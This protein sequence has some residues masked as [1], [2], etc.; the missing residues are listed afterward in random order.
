MPDVIKILPP[1][2]TNQISA[3]EVIERPASIIKELVENSID[4]GSDEIIVNIKQ[5]GYDLIIVRDNGVGISKNDLPLAICR[6]ATSKIHAFSDLDELKS[7]GFRGEALASICAVAKVKITSKYKYS[8][9]HDRA[10]CLILDQASQDA[11][12]YSVIPA[13]HPVGT[14]IEIS[15]LFYNTPVRKRFQKSEKT[16]FQHVLEIF[17]KLALSNLHCSFSFFNDDKLIY[18]LLKNNKIHRVQKIFGRNF[19]KN[20]IFFIG[21]AQN[22]KLEGW[23]GNQYYHRSQSDQQYFFLNNRVIRDKLILNAIK[24]VYD[25]MI[26]VGRHPCYILYL[27]LDPDQIDVNVHPAKHEV[28]FRDSRW[29]HQFMTQQLMRVLKPADNSNQ[30]SY[31][32]ESLLKQSN[33]HVCADYPIDYESNQA[34]QFGNI[35]ADLNNNIVVTYNLSHKKYYI[36]NLATSYI[37]LCYNKLLSEWSKQNYLTP[38]VVALQQELSVNSNILAKSKIL[39]KLGIKFTEHKNKSENKLLISTLPYAL[40]FAD[41]NEVIKKY[42]ELNPDESQLQINNLFY[43]WA[44]LALGRLTDSL[45]LSE[46]KAILDQID[47]DASDA[48][49]FG[50]KQL[51]KLLEPAYLESLLE[52]YEPVD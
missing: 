43:H 5:A 12:N 29:V 47:V 38:S 9:D 35:I 14:T 16:E 15:D 52:V 39:N 19:V 8:E 1:L 11:D 17:Q 48:M 33:A 10:Y 51:Y 37:Y 44:N 28:R 24:Q 49:R 36:I 46:Q 21:E 22:I 26:P 50:S 34:L 32:E 4:A 23:L 40:R 2:I 27:Y 31:Q 20:S 3:G 30:Q 41:P 7:L 18:R 45:L 13:A 25:A 42:F 6:H